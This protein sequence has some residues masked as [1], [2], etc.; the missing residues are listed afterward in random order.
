VSNSSRRGYKVEVWVTAVCFFIVAVIGGFFSSIV[1]I[2]NERFFHQVPTPEPLIP[3]YGETMF[4]S[5]E[6][7]EVL[8]FPLHYFLLVVLSWIGVTLIG[9][10]WCIV[11]DRLEE[12]QRA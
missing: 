11:M 3:A 7:L 8:G 5:I 2:L 10:I 12:Q 4:V 1:V 6:G 9:A